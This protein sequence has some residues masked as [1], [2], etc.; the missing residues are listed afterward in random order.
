MATP[1]T[2]AIGGIQKQKISERSCG[3]SK[4]HRQILP[5]IS[6]VIIVRISKLE[7]SVL[8]LGC[9]YRILVIMPC[10][11]RCFGKFLSDMELHKQVG[12]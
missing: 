1:D 5:C 10:Q 9:C 12:S 3:I 8:S 11:F 7:G 4:T 6:A 2:E